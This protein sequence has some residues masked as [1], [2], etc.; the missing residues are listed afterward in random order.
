MFNRSAA[1]R[2]A[3]SLSLI[4]LATS[5][6]QA[7]QYAH[8]GLN[9]SPVSGMGLWTPAAPT[10]LVIRPPVTPSRHAKTAT[11][12]GATKAPVWKQPYAYGYFGATHQRHAYRSFGHQKNYTEWRIR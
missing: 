1:I 9:I 10:H 3:I 7:E 12:P 2:I 5:G 8:D 11:I 6:V 4:H